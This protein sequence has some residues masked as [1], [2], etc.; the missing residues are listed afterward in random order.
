MNTM[1]AFAMGR[2]NR[3]R[4]VMVFDWEKAAELIKETKPQIATAGLRGDWEYTGGTI[5]KNGKPVFDSY[6]Y[7]ASTWAVPE[8]HLDG[9]IIPCYRMQSE[10]PE[11]HSDTKWP[12]SVLEIVGAIVFL[13]KFLRQPPTKL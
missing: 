9:K 3:G 5:W 11:W 8:L 12:E 2:A 4:E 1:D 6:T 13:T 7:L 10:V